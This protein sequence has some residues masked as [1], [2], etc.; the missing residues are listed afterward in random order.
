MRLGEHN[1]Y[2]DDDGASPVDYF[3]ERIIMHDEYSKSP[4]HYND[5]ALISLDREVV[6]TGT[7]G[8]YAAFLCNN[9]PNATHS[10]V[11]DISMDVQNIL[12]SIV[13]IVATSSW[14]VICADARRLL[15]ISIL[16]KC[17]NQYTT[18]IDKQNL[19]CE[20]KRKYFTHEI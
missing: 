14:N 12:E 4:Q 11:A 18:S 2:S 19:G 15:A 7:S 5:I 10:T 6:F 17:A 1:I 16:R 13:V 3:P 20:Y 9:R 8:V